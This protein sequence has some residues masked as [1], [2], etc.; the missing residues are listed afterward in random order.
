MTAD[1]LTQPERSAQILQAKRYRARICRDGLCSACVH[2]Q[3]TLGI[4]HCR[5]R[6]DR[7]QGMCQ[8][9]K[10]APVF[11]FDAGVLASLARAA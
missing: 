8:H 7:Q 4:H 3:V 9:D 6:E 1:D 2:R 10:Q 11:E 5:D